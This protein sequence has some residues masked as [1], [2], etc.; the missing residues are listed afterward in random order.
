[1]HRRPFEGRHLVPCY[2]A[3]P[4]PCVACYAV[5]F[6]VECIL[7][8][9]LMANIYFL[10]LLFGFD[11]L[12]YNYLQSA[13]LFL[14]GTAPVCPFYGGLLC[15]ARSTKWRYVVL[16][17]VVSCWVALCRVALRCVVL[18]CVVSCRVVLRCV[19]LR[20]VVSCQWHL[21]ILCHLTF[22]ARLVLPIT[23]PPILAP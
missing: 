4:S 16:R 21:P 22:R 1:M 13:S 17:C 15:C 5:N 23:F 18:R 11:V 10:Y 14:G 12:Q 8:S 3:M 7:A 6:T 19:V 9:T 2:K 20:C